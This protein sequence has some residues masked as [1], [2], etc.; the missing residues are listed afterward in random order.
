MQK[1]GSERIRPKRNAA[2]VDENEEILP[3]LRFAV[4]RNGCSPGE[5][6]NEVS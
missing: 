5:I 3:I 1:T 2:D 6:K 4:E